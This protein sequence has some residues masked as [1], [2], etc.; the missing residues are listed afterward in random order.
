V[1][2]T[3]NAA[4]TI[5]YPAPGY[6]GAAAAKEPVAVT[7]PERSC[8]ARSDIE[9][10][11]STCCNA[12]NRERTAN[13]ACVL[14]LRRSAQPRLH[15]R[16]S[17]STDICQAQ[18]SPLFCCPAAI[19]MSPF[20]LWL[21]LRAGMEASLQ[22]QPLLRWH[23]CHAV[24]TSVHE[25]MLCCLHSPHATPHGTARSGHAVV[26]AR[27]I[28]SRPPRPSC[29]STLRVHKPPGARTSC[30]HSCACACCTFQHAQTQ[31]QRPSLL[32][33]FGSEPGM[34]TVASLCSL[35]SCAVWRQV[36]VYPTLLAE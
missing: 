32:D 24:H 9:P 36:Q 14:F 27:S 29:G 5:L 35:P 1:T 30:A 7:E 16:P 17:V 22:A 6:G 13:P 21:R 15:R 18:P 19:P 34:Q 4:F 20:C 33:C 28:L 10:D 12:V 23:H 26:S 11:V 8:Y 31:R 25:A 3:A 2:R